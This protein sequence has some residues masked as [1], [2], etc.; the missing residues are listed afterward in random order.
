M[1]CSLLQSILFTARV[2]LVLL[3]DLQVAVAVQQSDSALNSG[4][5]L[6]VVLWP[7]MTTMLFVCAIRI[8]LLSLFVSMVGKK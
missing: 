5:L 1:F 7:S 2:A 3:S 8:W 6:R 4:A